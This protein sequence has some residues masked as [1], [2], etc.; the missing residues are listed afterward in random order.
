VA[1]RTFLGMLKNVCKVIKICIVCKK[2]KGKE[3]IRIVYVIAYSRAA[4]DGQ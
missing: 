3:C 2:A 4:M 1:R